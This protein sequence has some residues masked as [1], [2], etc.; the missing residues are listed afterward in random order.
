MIL[1]FKFSFMQGEF[2]TWDFVDRMFDIIF[3]VDLIFV[4]FTPYYKGKELIV[5]H[6][7]IAIHYIKSRWFWI[8]LVSIFPWDFFF[9]ADHNYSILL[10]IWKL[11]R[12]Y[13]MVFF[14]LKSKKV[15]N[16]ETVQKFHSVQAEERQL[17]LVQVEE[18][19]FE[20]EQHSAVDSNFQLYFHHVPLRS[21]HLAFLRLVRPRPGHLD[22][23]EQLP[24]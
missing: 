4:F 14:P 3:L 16:R 8:D 5:D 22:Q 20:Q 24:R 13:K 11:P 23:S 17:G 9:K 6:K 7:Q 12:F 19:S 15:E 21:L 10:R 18:C 2:E 1:P